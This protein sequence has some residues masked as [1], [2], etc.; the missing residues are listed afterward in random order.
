MKILLL[1]K[2]GLLGQ[3]L[4]NILKEHHEIFAPAHNECDITNAAQLEKCINENPP[5]IAIN[6][7]GYTQVDKA[8]QE[9]KK[10]FL[11]NAQSV[12]N[13]A[14]ILNQKNIPLVHFSTDYVFDGSKPEGYSE[15]ES[16]NPLSI[17][18]KSKVEGEK[19][20][21][22]IL[23]RYYLIRTAWLYGPGKKNFVDTIL[24]LSRKKQPL[25]IVNDQIGNP[26]LTLD[27][28]QAVLRLL[29]S[30][31][32][33]IYHIVNDGSCSWYEFAVEIF[34]QIG[35]PQ[36]I[37]PIASEELNRPAKRPK[38]SILLNTKL[39][40]LRHFKEALKSYLTEKTLI[41]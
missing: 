38:Y 37:I 35:V 9:K 30:K 20:I 22:N 24:E 2:T 12:A 26:T 27:V 8:E 21:L 29:E 41:L 11:I 19:H 3:A 5:E 18:A 7:T 34:N 33:G 15:N 1:G 39:P 31:N 32:Y 36:E 40:R 23:N 13:L 25:K 14:Q 28:A 4:F 6:A 10:A 16:P 17:Y